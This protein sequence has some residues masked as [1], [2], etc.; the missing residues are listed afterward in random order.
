M[1]FSSMRFRD[2]TDEMRLRPLAR[3]SRLVWLLLARAK[4]PQDQKADKPIVSEYTCL[5]KLRMKIWRMKI[6]CA[7]G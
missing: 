4:C 6:L 1:A 5:R 2:G 3:A 7:A